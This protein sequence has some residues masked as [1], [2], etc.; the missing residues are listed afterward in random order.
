MFSS[1][2]EKCVSCRH[3][4]EEGYEDTS[5]GEEDSFV[6]EHAV[7][8]AVCHAECLHDA[9]FS[10]SCDDADD[11][12]ICHVHECDQSDEEEEAVGKC[13]EHAEAAFGC[14]QCA[15]IGAEFVMLFIRKQVF[16]LVLYVCAVLWA[17]VY[18][19]GTDAFFRKVPADHRL[20]L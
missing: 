20:H 5:G 10:F 7:H 9:E 11:Y 18:P 2:A 14:L 8:L 16:Q 1:V 12:G 3:A 19:D 6:S 15:L 17:A 4:D 13:L